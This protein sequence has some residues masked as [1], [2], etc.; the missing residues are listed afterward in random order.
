MD[1]TFSC[2]CSRNEPLSF[3]QWLNDLQPSLNFTTDAEKGNQLPFF[4][5][6]FE[7]RSFALVTSIHRKPTFIGLYLSWDA[8]ALKS[9]KVNQINCLTFRALKIFSDNRSKSEFE[10]IK[11]I[12]MGNRYPEEVIVET[13][14]QTF[15]KFRNNI[16]PFGPPK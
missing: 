15:D 7:R 11:N 16:M 10:L 8:F 3:F 2:F 5:V 14:N 12:F 6:M 13:M 9:R 1:D 4:D